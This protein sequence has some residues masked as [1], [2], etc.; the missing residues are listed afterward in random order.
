MQ[1]SESF[2][3]MSRCLAGVFQNRDQAWADP[4]WFV[5]L[6]LW[7]CPTSLF[8][9]DSVTFFLE[10]A[11]AA[12][13]QPPYRQRIL[14]LRSQADELTAEYYALT[15]P[16]AFQGAGQTPEKLQTLHSTHLIPL[17]GSRLSVKVESE[18]GATR[19][20]ARQYPGERCQF[21]V[22]DEVKS[23]ELAFDAIVPSEASQQQVAFWMYD[24]GIDPLTNKPTWGATNGPFKLIKVQDLS[25]L[26]PSRATS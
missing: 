12:F 19:F 13:T 9:E 16:Q 18:V 24:K 8:A 10:Q 25:G 2:W 3:Q 22:D 7:I 5:H 1:L 17:T 23:V 26:L 6:R 20:I 11:S 15:D 21:R 4:A 14:R